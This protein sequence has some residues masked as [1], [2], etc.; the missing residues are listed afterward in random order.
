M[1]VRLETRLIGGA[2]AIAMAF[3]DPTDRPTERASE[4]NERHARYVRMYVCIVCRRNEFQNEWEEA[5]KLIHF[6]SLTFVTTQLI[7]IA[8]LFYYVC[9]Y[10]HTFTVTLRRTTFVL[11]FIC[12]M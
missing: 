4:D 2:H 12:V 11:S 10:I 3:S 6:P 8:L 1:C 7:A 9:T 5:S